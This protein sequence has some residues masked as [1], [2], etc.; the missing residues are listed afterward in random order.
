VECDVYICLAI[1]RRKAGKFRIGIYQPGGIPWSAISYDIYAISAHL[2]A[3]SSL[4]VS[5]SDELLNNLS[6]TP[7]ENHPASLP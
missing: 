1:G 7:P 5:A 3:G 6:N 4:C 2:P